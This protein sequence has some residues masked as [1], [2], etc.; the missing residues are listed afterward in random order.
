MKRVFLT[1]ALAG[2]VSLEARAQSACASLQLGWHF[3]C[4]P[5]PP[6]KAEPVAPPQTISPSE[7]DPVEE[8]TAIRKELQ[9]RRARA[10][11]DPTPENIAAYLVYQGE[12]LDQARIFSDAW[13]RLLWQTPELDYQQEK[14]QGTLAKRVWTSA[15]KQEASQILNTLGERYGVFFFFSSACPYCR[16]FSPV[17][18]SWAQRHNISVLAVS[19]DGGALPEWPNP[20]RDTGQAQRFGL[21][22]KPVPAL[23]LF[24]TETE[25]ILPVGFGLLTADELTARITTL[26]NR[27][28][29]NAY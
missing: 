15:R 14:P 28:I 13:Q 1:I 5:A 10:I 24:D 20:V 2:M 26:T 6:A 11:L 16:A 7:P 17:L 29:G 19:L 22:G 12:Q 4:D 3:Y 27:E 25:T 23:V 9:I 21:A 8:I 18:H